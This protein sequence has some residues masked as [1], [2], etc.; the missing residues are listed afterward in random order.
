MLNKILDISLKNRLMV[1]LST[2]VL[3]VAGIFVFRSMNVDVF[4]DLTAPTVTLLTEAHGMESEEV[5]KLVTYQLETAMNGSPNVRRIRSSSAAGI[6]IVWVE[7]QWGTDIYRA[8]QIVSERIPMVRESLPSGVG[9]P[10]MAPISSIMG[11]V[12]L[13]G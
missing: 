11:E 10:T 5:E 9:T 7:F 12:M 2:V 1:L 4:P 8:R 3:T 13:L 6:S